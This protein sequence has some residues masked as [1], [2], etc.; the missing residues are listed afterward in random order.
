MKENIVLDH[1]SLIKTYD[2][3]SGI[4]IKK[5]SKSV[6]MMLHAMH[7]RRHALERIVKV[8]KIFNI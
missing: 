4:K 2:D 1:I 6:D 7:R 5:L 3:V 8:N